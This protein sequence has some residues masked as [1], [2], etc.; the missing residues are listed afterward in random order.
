[1]K[2]SCLAVSLFPQIIKGEMDILDYIK[3]MKRLNL[4]GFDLGMILLKN[5][6]D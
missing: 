3:L 4:D 6:S 1:M 2:I 5:K